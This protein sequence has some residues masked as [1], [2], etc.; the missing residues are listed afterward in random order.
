MWTSAALTA[1]L[2]A[3]PSAPKPETDAARRA[4]AQMNVAYDADTFVLYA[5]RGDKRVVE[6]FVAAGFPVDRPEAKYAAPALV[7]A[8]G[9]GHTNIV[10]VLLRAGANPNAAM[11]NGQTALVAAAHRGS[12]DVLTL[13]LEEGADPDRRPAEGPTAL[14]AAVEAG[15]AAVVDRLLTGGAAADLADANGTT[16]LAAATRGGRAEIAKKLVDAGAK[17]G[18]SPAH[19]EPA[20]ATAAPTPVALAS[21]D[22][23]GS[24][25]DRRDRSLPLPILVKTSRELVEGLTT[26]SKSFDP[27]AAVAAMRQATSKRTAEDEAMARKWHSGQVTAPWTELELEMFV[28]H[29]IM[30]S[31][32]ARALGVLHV[33]MHDA[34]VVS[35]AAR[36]QAKRPAPAAFDAD[37]PVLAAVSA[38]RTTFPSER[39]AVAAAAAEVLTYLFPSEQRYFDDLAKRV[40]AAQ[41]SAGTH[42]PTDVDAGLR[43]GHRIAALVIAHARTDG[44][45]RG[46]NGESLIWHGEGRPFGPGYWEPTPRYHYYP[47]DEPYAPSWRPWLLETP[48]Q[49][50]PTPPAYGSAPYRRALQE[51]K[52]IADALTPEQ[53]RVA[54]FWVDGHGTVTPAGHWNQIALELVQKHDLDDVATADLL[55]SLNMALADAFIASWDAKYAYWTVRPIMAIRAIYGVPFDSFLLTPPF[56]SYVSGHATFSG[57]ASEVL[58]LRFPADAPR[59]RAM[60]EEAALSRLWGGIHYRFDNEDGLALGRRIARSAASRKPR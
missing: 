2:L 59:L 33:A 52:D 7:Y 1:L 30:P 6:L 8:A 37:L 16:P 28:K 40:A 19:D 14:I 44:S 12:L 43:L 36:E 29:K 60:G 5:G 41:V 39:A 20:P 11:R 48:D 24:G 56:P 4:L 3:A 17:T 34:L 22:V 42:F 50:R 35:I 23:D 21:L 57:A 15:H 10:G 9:Q 45:E 31:R 54:K 47:P 25:T 46:W 27:A 38:P 53:K 55:A 32:A 49:F 26:D 58:A 13:L 18:E 51:V